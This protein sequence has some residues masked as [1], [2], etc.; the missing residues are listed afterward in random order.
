[1]LLLLQQAHRHARLNRPRVVVRHG[2]FPLL[3]A[4]E[5]LRKKFRNDALTKICTEILV[6]P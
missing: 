5:I 4:Q 1:M 6:Y 2:L 3:R